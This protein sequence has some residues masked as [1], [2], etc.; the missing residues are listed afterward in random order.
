MQYMSM[1]VSIS[2][3]L[4]HVNNQSSI[5][6]GLEGNLPKQL[7][8]KS[9]ETEQHAFCLPPTKYGQMSQVLCFCRNNNL[10]LGVWTDSH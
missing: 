8:T 4:L 3:S 5:E 6:S 2:S 10:A 9:S 1:G 7:P